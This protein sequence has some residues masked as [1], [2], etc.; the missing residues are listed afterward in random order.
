MGFGRN[1]LSRG[2]AAVVGGRGDGLGGL[3]DSA[4]L[5]AEDLDAALLS[6]DNTDSLRSSCQFHGPVV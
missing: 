6:R 3:L 1:S 5:L 4:L 2:L